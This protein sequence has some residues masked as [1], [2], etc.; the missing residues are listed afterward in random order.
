VEVE[1]WYY[2]NAKQ[3]GLWANSVSITAANPL[4]GEKKK[5]K[6]TEDEPKDKD[7]KEAKAD[8]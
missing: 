7:K 5:P 3:A 4:T 1:G 6:P 8:K 2:T